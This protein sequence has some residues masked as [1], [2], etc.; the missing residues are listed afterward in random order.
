MIPE[1]VAKRIIKQSESHFPR[2]V[3]IRRHLH[4]HPEVSY[5]EFETT[6][7]ITTILDGLGC[8]IHLPL[9]TGCV[10]VIHGGRKS[11][12]VVALRAD[13]DA[14][15][16]EETGSAKAGFLSKNPG[17]AHCCGHDAHTANL[18]GAAHVLVDMKE[19]MEGDVVLIFQPG[20]EK[21]PGGSR[22][23]C[24]NG[25]LDR[26]GVQAIYGLHTSPV[27][28]PGTVGVIK[29]RAMARP[30]EFRLSVIGTG[31][32]AAVPHLAVDP[33]VTASHIITALQTITSR[34]INPLE[35][36]VVTVGKIRGGSVHN[37]IPERVDMLGTIRSFS[38]ETSM[39]ISKR[40][41]EIADGVTK[42]AG[43][44]YEYT[45]NEGYPA[46][47]NTGW[48]IDVVASTA[49][50]LQGSDAVFWL[51]EPVMGGED[52]AFY[53]EK[54]PGAFFLLGTGSEEAD[55]LYSWHHPAYNIDERAFLTGAAVMAGIAMNPDAA[56]NAV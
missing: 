2:I 33:I 24:E 55:S 11:D 41:Q 5:K 42:A 35:P 44:T 27:C 36:V 19:E 32:H 10:A 28:R 18:L 54:Y 9:E 15:P 25:I 17:A 34:N 45:H 21:L 40:I 56:G 38:R 52:F 12:R 39:H 43:A 20:E 22:L 8:E 53:L 30:D 1:P 48:A 51:P 6:Q 23:I 31:G 49:Q 14:L 26:L 50:C 47:I 29:G 46:V 37:V 4:M 16:M 3:E 7:Y 13:I